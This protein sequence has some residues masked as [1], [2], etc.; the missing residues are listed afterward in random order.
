MPRRIALHG[1]ALAAAVLVIASGARSWSGQ[2]AGYGIETA[3]GYQVSEVKYWLGDASALRSVDFHLDAP[4]HHVTTR[5]QVAGP[6]YRCRPNGGQSWSCPV[7]GVPRVD[8]N[9]ADT[10]QVRAY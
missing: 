2:R 1:V 8:M 6:W 5:L 4:A 7:V 9:D 10:F 3:T